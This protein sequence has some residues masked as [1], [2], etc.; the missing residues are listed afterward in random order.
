MSSD[1]LYFLGVDGGGSKCR[2]RIRDAQGRILGESVGGASNIYQDFSGAIATIVATASDAAAY[3]GLDMAWL[4]A[5]MGLAGIVTSVGA[6]KIEAANLPFAS[7]IADNDAYAACMGAFSG[8]D[9]GIVIAGTGS[10]GF[11]LVGGTRHMVGGW[12]FQ[13]GDHGSGAW[14][15]HHAVRRAALAIDGLLQPTRLVENILSRAGR[16]R[17]DLSRWSEQAAP[18]DYAQFAPIVFECAASGDVQGMMIVIEGAAAI[19]NL[20]RALLAR[21]TKTICLLGGLSKVYPPYLDADVKRALVEP[22]ADAM[23]GAIMMARRARGLPER[24]A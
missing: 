6:E 4:H 22:Q 14:V 16:T 23:D 19:S 12:G 24:W 13:L 3:A 1:P 20:G 17:F 15:G 5:G 11:G 9:G 10:I 21:G 2:V 18:K 7:V 8:E